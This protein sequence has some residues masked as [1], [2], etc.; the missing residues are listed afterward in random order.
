MSVDAF[1]SP[2]IPSKDPAGRKALFAALIV[3][4]VRLA[5]HICM[6]TRASVVQS[7]LAI[8]LGVRLVADTLGWVGAGGVWRVPVSSSNI[9]RNRKI[10]TNPSLQVKPHG[11]PGLQMGTECG[12]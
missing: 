11:L 6:S 4:E 12:G 2:G 5:L 3:S 9:D 8:A 10:A 1:P 7:T